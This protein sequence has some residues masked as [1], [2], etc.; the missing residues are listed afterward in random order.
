M[1]GPVALVGTAP[2]RR[3]AALGRHEDELERASG[4]GGRAAAAA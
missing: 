4:I 3:I 2:E 1:S